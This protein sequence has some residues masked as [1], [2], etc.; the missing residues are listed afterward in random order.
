MPRDNPGE[1]REQSHACWRHVHLCEKPC[2]TKS[3]WPV[4]IKIE[5]SFGFARLISGFEGRNR[6]LDLLRHHA[7]TRSNSGVLQ[8]CWNKCVREN[9]ERLVQ[10][11]AGMFGRHACPEANSILRHRRIIHRRDPEAASP[12]LMTEPIHPFA[13]ADDNRHHVGCRLPGINSETAKLRMKII[14]VLPKL[15]TQVWL[16]CAKLKRFENS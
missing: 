7:Q 6:R 2:E 5:N 4:E 13:I 10:I 1:T 14:G 9:V 16:T 15:R 8:R 12:Q 3:D 11:R